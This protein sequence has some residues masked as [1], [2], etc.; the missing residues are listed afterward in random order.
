MANELYRDVR[1]AVHLI[2]A[3][4]MVHQLQLRKGTF[5]FQW[6][7][8]E[9]GQTR[10]PTKP[11]DKLLYLVYAKDLEVRNALGRLIELPKHSIG[12]HRDSLSLYFYNMILEHAKL[13]Y[14]EPNHSTA[15][16]CQV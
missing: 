5:Y 16:S 13:K 3:Q 12:Y 2:H 8:R 10:E 14:T 7:H 15:C 1:T 4:F 6:V 11:I 9:P